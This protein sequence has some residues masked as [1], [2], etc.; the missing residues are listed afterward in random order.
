MLATACA[1]YLPNHISTMSTRVYYYFAG[2]VET[3]VGGKG[4]EAALDAAS[5]L[6]GAAYQAAVNTAA[7]AQ[8]AATR[9]AEA[10]GWS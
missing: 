9:A 8:D 5:D 7:V 3:A 4:S 10:L 2:D 6:A 1:L